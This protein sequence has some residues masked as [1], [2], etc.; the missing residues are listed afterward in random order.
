M[1]LIFDARAV[2]D[3]ASAVFS[4]RANVAGVVAVELTSVLSISCARVGGGGEGKGVIVW[5]S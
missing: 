1:N 3:A 4:R 5:L 2:F